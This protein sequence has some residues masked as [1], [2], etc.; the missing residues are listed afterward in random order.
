MRDRSR[1]RAEPRREL[2]ERHGLDD[3]VVG[4]VVEP[5]DA[6][7]ERV[8]T[9]QHQH[10]RAIAAGTQPAQYFA[11]VEPRQTEVEHHRAEAFRGECAV[12]RGAVPHPVGREAGLAQALQQTVAELRIVLDDEDSHRSIIVAIAIDGHSGS[13]RAVATCL[14]RVSRGTGTVAGQQPADPERRHRHRSEQAYCGA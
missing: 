6:I 8:A 13:P 14:S 10:R 3:V 9:R 4:A 12:G 2:A 11:A 5:V 7:V 1:Q